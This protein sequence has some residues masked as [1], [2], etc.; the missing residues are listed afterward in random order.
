MRFI[1]YLPLLTL[2]ALLLSCGGRDT[3]KTEHSKP[4]VARE[5]IHI[6]TTRLAHNTRCLALAGAYPVIRGIVD[7]TFARRVNDRLKDV[8]MGYFNK[9]KKEGVCDPTELAGDTSAMGMSGLEANGS[10]SVL[11]ADERTLSLTQLFVSN[12]FMGNAWGFEFDVVNFDLNNKRALTTRDL[13]RGG[14][15]T[16]QINQTVRQ[17]FDHQ[18]GQD[19]AID[20]PVIRA[21]GLDSLH[22]AVRHDSLM[23]VIEA[24]PTSHASHSIYEIPLAKYPQ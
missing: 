13:L 7:E 12:P 10:F 1:C 16:K 6:D 15:S 20:Y 24:W 17:Y 18:F 2:S 8:F 5:A 14:P 22:L 19:G 21:S 4:M 3:P 9:Y 23:L 11:T